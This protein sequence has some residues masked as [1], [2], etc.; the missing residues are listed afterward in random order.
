MIDILLALGMALVCIF[1]H[2]EAVLL[3]D[4][5]NAFNSVNRKVF[6]H[7]IKVIWPS[8][9]TFVQNCYQFPSR[10]FVFGGKEL[11][12]TEGTTQGDP[13]AMF[14]Y[15]IATIPLI[16]KT[17]WQTEQAKENSKSAGYADDL[18]GAGSVRGLKKLWQYIKSEGPKYGYH[19]EESKTWLIVKPEF[20]SE[21]KLIFSDTAVNVTTNGRKHLGAAIGSIE[22]R[23]EFVNKK[24]DNWISELEMLAK[25]AIFASISVMN[26]STKKLTTG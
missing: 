18:F 22:F 17:V 6:L 23:D 15:A 7:N 10:L 9:S 16:L 5:K 19:Q 2:F 13:V 3:I 4:A 12:S 25:L 24:V 1:L 14:V 8:L 21:A 11:Q 26:L 20:L